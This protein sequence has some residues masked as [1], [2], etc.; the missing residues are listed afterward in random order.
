MRL[1]LVTTMGR[2]I[3]ARFQF[4]AILQRTRN[5]SSHKAMDMQRVQPNKPHW[6]H[7]PSQWASTQQAHEWH[8][9]IASPQHWTSNTATA[10]HPPPPNFQILNSQL[11]WPF[12]PA[13]PPALAQH[14]NQLHHNTSWR[15]PTPQHPTF[16]RPHPTSDSWQEYAQLV[17]RLSPY[18]SQME[19]LPTPAPSLAP[20]SDA[21]PLLRTPSSPTSFSPPRAASEPGDVERPTAHKLAFDS[22]VENIQV[23]QHRSRR[24]H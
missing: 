19:R 10:T 7:M 11:Q 13:F 24:R 20:A 2:R 1:T 14:D 22:S 15:W 23:S 18:H 17:D 3:S 5:L 8:W 16:I 12:P 9:H 4:T 6:S 21:P